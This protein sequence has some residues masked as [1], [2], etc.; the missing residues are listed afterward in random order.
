MELIDK[1]KDEFPTLNEDILLKF[2]EEAK[3][4]VKRQ[5]ERSD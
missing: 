1:L 3:E 2:I 4:E 5:E